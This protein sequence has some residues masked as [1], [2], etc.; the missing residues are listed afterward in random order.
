MRT[1]GSIIWATEL[2]EHRETQG[3]GKGRPSVTS[4]TYSVSFA[5]ALASR[6][7]LGLGR[8][9]AD[10][11]LLRGEAGDLKTGG[12]MRLYTG[13]GDQEA[14]P[15]IEAIEGAARTPAY[16]DLAYVVFEA[17]NS[18]TSTTASPR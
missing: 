16:R 6:P 2:V 7:I 13:R 17:W 15:L 8:I 12:T 9:W 14:D 1:A 5:V 18:S 11:N 4:Y 10:G 3:G